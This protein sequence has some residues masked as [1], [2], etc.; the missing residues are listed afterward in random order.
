MRFFS[1]CFSLLLISSISWASKVSNITFV[2]YKI[3]KVEFVDGYVEYAGE[4]SWFG[5]DK[6]H[7]TPLN[8]D[9]AVLLENYQLKNLSDDQVYSPS[10]IGR[11]SKIHRATWKG[12]TP[13]YHHTLYLQFE[14]PLV[15]GQDYQLMIE[16]NLVED[17]HTFDLTFANDQLSSSI[18][19]T[20]QGFVPDANF[21]VGYIYQWMGDQAMVDFSDYAGSNFHLVD[22]Q[23]G[24]VVFTGQVQLRTTLQQATDN[25]EQADS[26]VF[27][28]GKLFSR[29]DVYECNFSDFSTAGD[30]V[31]QVEGIGRSYPFHIKANAYEEA[32]YVTT[33]GLYHHRSGPARTTEHT[34]W[35]KGVD[36]MPGVDNF[37][38]HYSNFRF[39]DIRKGHNSWFKD[40]V[41]NKTNVEMPEAWGAWMDAADYDRQA[42][43]MI[44]SSLFALHYLLAPEK[45]VD[46]DLNIPESGNGIP[47]IIDEAIWGI[48]LFRRCKGPTG[49]II[50]GVEANDHPSSYG[51]VKDS[52]DP[53][54]QWFTYA[55]DPMSSYT[56]AAAM[57][58]I[59]AALELSGNTFSSQSYYNEAAEAYQWAENNWREGDYSKLK[60]RRLRAAAWMYYYTG[61]DYFQQHFKADYEARARDEGTKGY[62]M[63]LLGYLMADH[64]NKDEE[65]NQTVHHFIFDLADE[66][67]TTGSQRASRLASFDKNTYHA[68][69]H[70]TTP[71][72]T[73]LN[74]AYATTGQQEYLDYARTTADYF[75]GGNAVNKT[76]VTG[77]GADPVTEVFHLDS[78]YDDQEEPVPGIV[79]YGYHTWGQWMKSGENSVNQP[80][81]NYKNIYPERYLWPS[82]ECWFPN[83]YTIVTNE[84]TI[85][86]NIAPAAMAYGFLVPNKE[87][88]DRNATQRVVLTA[89]MMHQV[90]EINKGIQLHYLTKNKQQQPIAVRVFINGELAKTL[91]AVE[92]AQGFAEFSFTEKGAHEIYMEVDFANEQISTK[93]EAV[94]V[95]VVDAVALEL[96]F[97]EDIEEEIHQDT[98]LIVVG[99][100]NTTTGIKEAKLYLDDQLV[101]QK[102]VLPIEFELKGLEVGEH[103]LKMEVITNVL[104]ASAVSSEVYDITITDR[105]LDNEPLRHLA[106]YP[107]PATSEIFFSGVKSVD[108]A[109]LIDLQGQTV[110]Q[111]FNASEMHLQ[112]VANGLYILQVAFGTKVHTQKMMIVR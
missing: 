52:S 6:V 9:Q 77:L 111:V 100:L 92:I 83:R 18:H 41:E 64:E 57:V 47:D 72:N 43:H 12:H 15:T 67:V 61:L 31:L 89:P 22:A 110:K 95:E 90:I 38:V 34:Q 109:A 50:G 107:N 29:A 39:M 108:H 37:K 32:Y 66:L 91:T 28:D 102:E 56:Y 3:I 26:R 35:T 69:G 65:L 13:I 62:H 104:T 8:V 55:E 17:E 85:W 60:D 14:Q 30:Y 49:G 73:L 76:Y 33:R 99:N 68:V 46:G 24:S 87:T 51:S 36:H 81:F 88:V 70:G 1:L 40:L 74:F 103:Q 2:T 101:A 23:S 75:L 63:G 94:T 20:Q 106:V 45:F 82:H 7:Q 98:T 80:G 21:K 59:A 19:I 4:G 53:N 16:E 44:V 54:M 10:V 93:E 112:G 79:P 5:Q 97:S 27:E 48:D 86:Q 42:R 96:S 71:Y 78:F 84:Y 58:Q 105:V 25:V 11:K